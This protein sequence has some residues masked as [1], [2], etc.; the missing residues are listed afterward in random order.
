MR[1]LVITGILLSVTV[2]SLFI[3][4]QA[5]SAAGARFTVECN[6]SPDCLSQCYCYLKPADGGPMRRVWT[7]DSEPFQYHDGD[8]VAM[9]IPTNCVNA[10]GWT[11]HLAGRGPDLGSPPSDA[12]A[13]YDAGY[14]LV[15]TLHCEIIATN[16]PALTAVWFDGSPPPPPPQA[17]PTPPQ[18]TIQE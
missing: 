6:I 15:K 9:H 4:R 7:T 12:A 3:A 13:F 18:N 14:D 10:V 17:S 5:R 8:Q 2:G 1:K 11:L 16:F